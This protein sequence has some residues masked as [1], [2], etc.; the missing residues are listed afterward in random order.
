MDKI[1]PRFVCSAGSC[2]DGQF[3]C[4]LS[5]QCILDDFVCDGDND[6]G[7]N[8]D[9]RNCPHGEYIQCNNNNNNNNNI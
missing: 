2:G 4:P 9:E 3:R 7:D 6:C 8:A 5:G 1:G